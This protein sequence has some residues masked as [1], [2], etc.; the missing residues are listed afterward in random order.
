M[1]CGLIVNLGFNMTKALDRLNWGLA[2]QLPWVSTG[3][4]NS[5]PRITDFTKSQVLE[6]HP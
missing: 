1:W 4:R 2:V 3:I 5:W 6:R